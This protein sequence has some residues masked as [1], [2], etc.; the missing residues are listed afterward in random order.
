[1]NKI[2]ILII[3][4]LL[5]SGCTRYVFI[6]VPIKYSPEQYQMKYDSLLNRA[7]S[8]S[9]FA[10]LFTKADSAFWVVPENKILKEKSEN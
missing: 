4:T 7:D 2:K 9:R 1:M 8:V 3:A 6:P 5:L 10:P